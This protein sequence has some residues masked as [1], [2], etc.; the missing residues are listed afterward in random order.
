MKWIVIIWCTLIVSV[1]FIYVW[2]DYKHP[3][4][5]SH[6]EEQWEMPASIVVWW[7]KYWWWIWVPMW[8][9]KLVKVEVCDERK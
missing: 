7:S 5:K 1:W 8:N 6:T 9:A 4:I 3:C 2:Y